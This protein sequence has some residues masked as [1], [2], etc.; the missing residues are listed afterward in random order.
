VRHNMPRGTTFDEPLLSDA[1]AY[2]V[3]AYVNS[4]ERPTKSNLE[5][6][7]PNKLQKPVDSPY[8]PYP[9]DF[10]PEQHKYGPFEA[11]RA[12]VRELNAERQAA[13][14]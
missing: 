9:D 5:K 4:F 12:K 1:Q 8:G 6:D 10:S 13:S 14:K 2:D 11:I 7:F 3:A